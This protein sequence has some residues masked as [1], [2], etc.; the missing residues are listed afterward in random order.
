MFKRRS[1]APALPK[2]AETRPFPSKAAGKK[3]PEA[4]HL[5]HLVSPSRPPA[6]QDVPSPDAR[7]AK[8]AP[9]RLGYVGDF[10]DPRT[11]FG[12]KRV[13]A[14]LGWVGVNVA[15]FNILKTGMGR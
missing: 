8:T 6:R 12:I 13:S 1:I 9:T 10:F 2:R 11:K 4:Y 5:T 7:A 14:R 15:F 3:K